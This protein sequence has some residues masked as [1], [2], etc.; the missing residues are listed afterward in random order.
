MAGGAMNETFILKG[1]RL[2][3]ITMQNKLPS[4]TLTQSVNS[5]LGNSGMTNSLLFFFSRLGQIYNNNFVCFIEV[6]ELSVVKRYSKIIQNQMIDYGYQ[7]H[8]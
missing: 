2:S 1:G 6:V 3:Q 7:F 8:S 4:V 5:L